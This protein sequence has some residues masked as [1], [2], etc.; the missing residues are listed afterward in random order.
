MTM[1]ASELIN[2]SIIT[3][4]SFGGG[5][6]L[7]WEESDRFID[8]VVDQSFLKNNARVERMSKATKKIDKIG[9][10]DRILIPAT[11]GVDPGNTVNV[12]SGQ[13]IL[14]A[15]EMIA[16]AEVSDDSLEDN[17]EG[18]AFVD[19][20]MK[21]IAGQVANELEGAYLLGKQI[22]NIGDA[23]DIS[24]LFDGWATRALAE[25]HVVD[26]NV[27]FTD[28]YIDS[29]KFS[30]MMKAMPLK[31]RRDRKNLRYLMADDIYQ[32]YNDKLAQRM[33]VGGDGFVQTLNPSIGYGNVGFQPISLLPT[34]MPVAK[35]DG[36]STTMSAPSVAGASTIT[37]VDV[38]KLAEGDVV[39]IAGSTGF[40]EVATVVAVDGA[41]KVAT[42]ASPLR[43][44]HATGSTVVEANEDGSFS[45]LCDYRNLICGIHRD[46]RVETERW[47][48]K[49][50]TAFI[51]TLRTDIQ[52]ENPEAVVLMKNLKVR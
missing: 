34:D 11:A 10:G 32:D 29:E 52:M 28:R 12:S 8:Y 17:I 7:S 13:I 35:A 1:K 4:G 22:P 37:L 46:I 30:R 16:I 5:I 20:L 51:L 41:G 36:E 38:T 44:A 49:R 48:R 27:G 21:M 43:F 31:Y 40:A 15:K 2:K 19:H 6:G 23:T 9:I 14:Q 26:A 3:S 33:T 47:A 25:G 39:Q 18:D 45:M 50:T 24:Q 42:F